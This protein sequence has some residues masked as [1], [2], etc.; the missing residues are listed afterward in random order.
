MGNTIATPSRSLWWLDESREFSVSWHHT[1]RPLELQY[2][3][4]LQWHRIVVIKEGESYIV[5]A[6]PKKTLMALTRFT[7]DSISIYNTMDDWL[8]AIQLEYFT[9]TPERLFDELKSLSLYNTCALYKAVKVFCHKAYA[10]DEET[11]AFFISCLQSNRKDLLCE[12]TF[13]MG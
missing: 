13:R 11:V 8:R 3:R 10:Y 12:S 2:N 5:K 9:Q 6:V 1:I 7:L 4:V